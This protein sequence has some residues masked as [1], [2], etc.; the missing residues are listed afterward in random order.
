MANTIKRYEVVKKLSD[1]A[2]LRRYYSI[3]DTQYSVVFV[4]GYSYGIA[5]CEQEDALVA[6]WEKECEEAKNGKRGGWQW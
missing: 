5:P 6:W 3:F 4:D 1:N 2:E